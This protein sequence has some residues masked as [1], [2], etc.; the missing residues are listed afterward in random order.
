MALAGVLLLTAC[1]HNEHAA[2]FTASGYA[3]AQVQC[4]SGVKDRGGETAHLLNDA[5]SVAQRQYLDQ[6]IPFAGHKLQL[7][8]LNI[9][10]KPSTYFAPV[11]DSNGELSFMQREN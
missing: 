10:G 9:Y 2:A 7:I 3:D 11:F 1:S 6:R 8:E 4:A 5:K